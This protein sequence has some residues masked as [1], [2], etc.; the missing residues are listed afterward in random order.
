[1]EKKTLRIEGDDP[2]GISGQIPYMLEKIDTKAI[3]YFPYTKLLLLAYYT[4][5]L[6]CALF[7]VL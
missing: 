5:L 4:S 2:R 1:M 7:D 6:F 3:P